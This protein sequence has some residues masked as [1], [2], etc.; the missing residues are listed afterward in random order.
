MAGPSWVQGAQMPC[1]MERKE[2][3]RVRASEGA[4]GGTMARERERTVVGSDG[5]SKLGPSGPDASHDGEL[6]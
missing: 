4:Q 6:E 5:G 2:R 1:A 3:R